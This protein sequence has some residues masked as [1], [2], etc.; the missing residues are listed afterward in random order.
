MGSMRS[1]SLVGLVAATCVSLFGGVALAEVE[2]AGY[3]ESDV[4]VT[5]PGHELAPGEIADRIYRL[6]NSNALKS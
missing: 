2:T 4:R 3:I 6:E 1:L 5:V